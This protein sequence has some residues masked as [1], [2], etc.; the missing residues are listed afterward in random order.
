ME[1][2]IFDFEAVPLDAAK[3]PTELFLA[4]ADIQAKATEA[5]AFNTLGGDG[6]SPGPLTLDLID[7]A[8]KRVQCRIYGHQFRPSIFAISVPPCQR[9]GEPFPMAC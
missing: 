6:P 8:I 2:R 7:R 3:L 4:V 1:Y 9:C 5:L